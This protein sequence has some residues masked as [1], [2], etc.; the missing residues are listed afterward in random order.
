[1]LLY[2]FAVLTSVVL[3]QARESSVSQPNV[4]FFKYTLLFAQQPAVFV[5]LLALLT[6]VVMQEV[7]CAIPHSESVH[8]SHM[9]QYYFYVGIADFGCDAR[10]AVRHTLH[11]FGQS[12]LKRRLLEPP[13][14]IP[15]CVYLA[16]VVGRIPKSPQTCQNQHRPCQH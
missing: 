9:F 5:F 1:M 14:W 4:F 12:S 16:I 3:Q 7:R 10:S 11:S 13:F 8:V 2:F 6:S 15:I